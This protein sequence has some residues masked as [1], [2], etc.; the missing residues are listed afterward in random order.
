MTIKLNYKNESYEDRTEE[1]NITFTNQRMIKQF[2]QIVADVTM[3]EKLHEICDP[4]NVNQRK[5]EAI[6][7]LDKEAAR[8]E[9]EKIDE[10]V[11]ELYPKYTEL[12]SPELYTRRVDLAIDIVKANNGG[13]L[14]QTPD[15]WDESV[16][17]S[18]LNNFLAASIMKDKKKA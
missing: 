6:M 12:C 2:S 5:A 8:A 1:F 7:G 9:C 3:L 10:E 17:P 14:F 11:K 18:D 16:D 4:N 15:F 13:A